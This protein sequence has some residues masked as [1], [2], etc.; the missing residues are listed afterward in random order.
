MADTVSTQTLYDN[1]RT[2][3]MK[4]TNISDGTGE[5][6]V[7]K[8]NVANLSANSTGQACTGVTITKIYAMTHGMQVSM[9][10]SATA[11]K[12]ICSVPQDVMQTMDLTN[13]PLW[14]DAG[15][16]KDGNIKFITRDAVLGDQ[17]T[18]ILEM[19]KTYA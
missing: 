11:N 9:Y 18:I 7:V 12:L 4:F 16:G 14:N 1:T 15:A 8:V 13:S 6:L 5:N 17:Y 19:T 3:I 10:W 2:A